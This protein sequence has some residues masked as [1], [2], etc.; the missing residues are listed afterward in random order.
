M[1]EADAIRGRVLG[2][3]ARIAAVWRLSNRCYF[4]SASRFASQQGQAS[5]RR[6]ASAREK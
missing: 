3:R 1:V 5:V 4:I 2:F 6:P